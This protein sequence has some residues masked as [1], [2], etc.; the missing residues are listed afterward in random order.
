MN[1]EDIAQ[2]IDTSIKIGIG[3]IV[4]LI[5]FTF[6]T[7][8]R[9][10]QTSTPLPKLNTRRLEILETISADV[11]NISHIFSK[12]STLVLES[13]RYGQQWPASRRDELDAISLELVSEFR[14][15]SDAEAKL[16][17][18]GEKTLQK[19][20][21]M[22]ASRIAHFRKNVYVGRQD[23]EESEIAELKKGINTLREQFYEFLSRKY[24]RLLPA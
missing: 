2:M 7:M 22:Y 11:G 6:F 19:N 15:L 24:D 9:Q 8:R 23:I 18:L 1:P 16:L 4:T 10:N 5:I 20:L 12:Y 13:I 21:R 14:K 17:M 3:A